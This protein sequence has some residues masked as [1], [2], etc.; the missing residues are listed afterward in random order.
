MTK[1]I[2]EKVLKSPMFVICIGITL[3]L[4][5]SGCVDY[6]RA[7]KDNVIDVLYLIR[8][9][10]AFG[11]VLYMI[12]V[13]AALPFLAQYIEELQG[14]IVYYKMI[15]SNPK[16][17]FRG[18]ILGAF[19]TSF[20]M[21]TLIMGILFVIFVLL[22]SGFEV[23]IGNFFE[24]TCM[25]GLYH[26]SHMWV[27]YLWYCILYILY[28]IPWVFFSLVFSLA[29][30]NRYILI[31]AP[32]VCNFA[33]SLI[34][35]MLYVKWPIVLWLWPLQTI[36]D[37]GLI[38]QDFWTMAHTILYPLIYHFGLTAVLASVYYFVSKRRF[39][40]EGI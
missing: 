6:L 8:V 40:C 34:V 29:T 32:F 33:W 19:L 22:G 15:R 14:K 17:Y 1:Q 36:L 27:L 30:T 28:G 18:Q 10:A 11:V 38:Y 4:W 23:G 20:I 35:E 9:S 2:I 31:A 39:L 12:P 25:Y 24:Q 3:F 13:L 16:T 37:A 5:I 26:S 7:C 21:G